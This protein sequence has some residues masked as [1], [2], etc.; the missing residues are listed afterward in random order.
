MSQRE[1]EA[2]RLARV[3]YRSK[4]ET[5]EKYRA[6]NARYRSS[7]SY[8]AYDNERQKKR[9]KNLDK[10]P[11]L[12]VGSL[13][14]R[15][16]RRGIE[17]TITTKDIVVPAVCPVL[18]IQLVVGVRTRSNSSPSVDRFDNSKGYVPGNIRVISNRANLL[19]SDATVAELRKIIDY[20]EG[21]L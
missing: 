17:C 16:L 19:K 4:A 9:R 15:A 2:A 21:K 13:R 5:K 18:G 1:T 3:R 20:M 7:D 11:S 10:W 8:R 14:R 12:I 6:T